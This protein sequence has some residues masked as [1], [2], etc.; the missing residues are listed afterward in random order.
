[1]IGVGDVVMSVDVAN[2]SGSRM[3]SVAV[4]HGGMRLRELSAVCKDLHHLVS[5]CPARYLNMAIFPG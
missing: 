3:I 5:T 4:R 1:M 2:V